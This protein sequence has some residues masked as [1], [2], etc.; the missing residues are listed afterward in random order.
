LRFAVHSPAQR[1]EGSPRSHRPPDGDVLGRVHIRMSDMPADATAKN[2][3]ALTVPRLA[4]PADMTDQRRVRRIDPLHPARSLVLKTPD[5]TAPT[6]R[7][8]RPVQS[9]LGPHVPARHSDTAAR[10][11]NHV[12]DLEILDADQIE[13]A[14]QI[15]R[16]LLHPIPAPIGLTR[17]D[18]AD[19]GLDPPT[20]V[21]PTVRTRQPALQPQQTPGL[22]FAQTRHRQQRAG[23]QSRRD[24][25][26]TVHT[27]DLT[28]TRPL[29]RRRDHR[30]RHMPTARPIP[31]HPKRPD[32]A[33]N[34]A[35]PT[36]PHPPHLRDPHLTRLAGQPPHIPLPTT[37]P[38]DPKP[39]VH[40]RLTP[41]RP[42]MRP[43]EKVT[44][45]L[46]E[47]TQRLLLH[48]LRTHRQPPERSPGPRQLT[49][50]LGI[51]RRAC[52]AR[53]P[54]LM[55][56]QHHLLG[57]RGHKPEPHPHTLTTTTDNPR[58]ERRFHP[59]LKTGTST[60]RSR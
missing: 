44:H 23:G 51:T 29:D 16:G 1:L 10:G 59:G 4:M 31:L 47:I 37:P 19:R 11:T 39:F 26:T 34:A 54:L 9:G 33:G 41:R 6:S 45:R 18:P 53:P 50:L 12:L 36:E 30:E 8:D 17:L 15:R 48:R 49:R 38:D 22:A 57:R 55:L 20:P 42:P 46:G 56:Q 13:T 25:H 14:G 43:G 40:P 3:L 24:H 21:R 27:H 60:P 52:P 35:G 2:R 32:L 58:R 7:V 28:R 5:K